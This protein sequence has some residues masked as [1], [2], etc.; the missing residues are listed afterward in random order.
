MNLPLQPTATAPRDGSEVLLVFHG[1]TRII[2]RSNP[3]G[4][5]NCGGVH[6]TDQPFSGWLDLEALARDAERLNHVLR[7]RGQCE[8][9]PQ[10]WIEE[11]FDQTCATCPKNITEWEQTWLMKARAAID[12]EMAK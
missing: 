10:P 11:V 2:G 3:L 9:Q 12:K 6:L 1:G 5:W 7:N 8:L 4:N